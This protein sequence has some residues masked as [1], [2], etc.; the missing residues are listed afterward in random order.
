LPGQVYNV[1]RKKHNKVK[2]VN[3]NIIIMKVNNEELMISSLKF[4]GIYCRDLPLPLD[5]EETV[6]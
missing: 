6:M 4:L 5:Q 1:R 2:E 3:I